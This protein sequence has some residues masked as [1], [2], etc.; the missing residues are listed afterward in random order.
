MSAYSPRPTLPPLDLHLSLPPPCQ[1]GLAPTSPFARTRMVA[2]A[3]TKQCKRG[4]HT[5]EAGTT[6][7]KRVA[8]HTI[9]SQCR[10]LRTSTPATR[11]MR[12]S[13]AS[14]TPRPSSA[15]QEAHTTCTFRLA[16]RPSGSIITRVRSSAGSACLEPPICVTGL[17]GAHGMEL[18][19]LR[20]L[21]TPTRHLSPIRQHTYVKSSTCRSSSLMSDGRRTLARTSRRGLGRLRTGAAP[22]A[23][24][25]QYTP[26]PT[27]IPSPLPP[28]IATARISPAAA[29]GSTV[30]ATTCFRGARRKSSARARRR[31]AQ[32]ATAHGNTTASSSTT[33]RRG[34]ATGMRTHASRCPFSFG[35]PTGQGALCFASPCSRGTPPRCSCPW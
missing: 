5:M 22:C 2:T 16:T 8:R 9:S 33:A 28:H 3:P 7:P 21:W 1:A 10:P 24:P 31:G 11:G 6:R 18:L 15:A 13:W 27:P 25:L 29:R 34:C 17:R 32:V 26:L 20:R 35:A 12:L 14:A 4:L 23:R 30:S 19:S